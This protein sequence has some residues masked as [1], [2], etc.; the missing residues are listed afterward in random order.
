[1]IRNVFY[2]SLKFCEFHRLS[3]ENVNQK[4]GGTARQ[5]KQ[6]FHAFVEISMHFI[7]KKKILFTL[8]RLSNFSKYNKSGL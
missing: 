2:R 5:I 8:P 4:G 7:L 3:N 6:I 1:M